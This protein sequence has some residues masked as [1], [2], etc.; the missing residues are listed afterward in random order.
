MHRLEV[1]GV[2]QL[3]VVRVGEET[4]KYISTLINKKILYT[5][6]KIFFVLLMFYSCKSEPQ[7]DI[8]THYSAPGRTM[9]WRTLN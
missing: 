4:D 7:S 8:Y 2:F 5:V 6:F 1:T 3:T 9:Q